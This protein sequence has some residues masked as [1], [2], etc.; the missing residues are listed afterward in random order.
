M[1][2]IN[3]TQLFS[4]GGIGLVIAGIAYKAICQ[5]YRDMREDSTKR[6]ERLMTH[7]DKVANTLER[8]DTRLCSLEESYHAIKEEMKQ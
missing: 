1:E 7:L 8:M 6:E 5:L 4:T 3:F 2:S